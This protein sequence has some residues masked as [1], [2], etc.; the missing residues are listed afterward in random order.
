[1]VDRLTG[2]IL[3]LDKDPWVAFGTL[4]QGISEQ[5]MTGISATLMLL[6]V[7]LDFASERPG[8]LVLAVAVT[9]AGFATAIAGLCL[10][11]SADL[12]SIWQVKHVPNSVFG[13][14]WYHGNTAAFLNLSWPAGVWLCLLLLHQVERTFLQQLALSCLVLAVMMQIVAVFVNVSKMGHLLLI[15]EVLLLAVLGMAVW[16]PHLAA[17]P[18]SKKR[19]VLFLLIGI[20]LLALGAWVSGASSGL[21][22]W[23]IFAARHFDDPAR[24][25]A[26][27]MALQIGWDHGWTGTGPGTFEWISPHYSALDPVLDEGRWRHA[28]NDYA[29][30]FAEWG[31]PG[32]L[33]FMLLLVLPGRRWLGALRQAVSNDSRLGMSFQRRTGLFCFSAALVAVLLHAMVDFPLQIDASRNLFAVMLGSVL[34]MTCSSG[35]NA[36]RRDVY[37][38]SNWH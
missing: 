21:G 12:S 6:V 35:R 20:G 8:R 32:A 28:H 10:Q 19:L 29:E 31:W 13:L 16:K 33:F 7:A 25:H 36:A 24:R 38:R 26:A 34:G 37:K 22:R 2:A 9:A 11:T 4:D 15:F 5:A 17:L 18:F 1:M 23:N 3:D 27:L 30:F 14:F